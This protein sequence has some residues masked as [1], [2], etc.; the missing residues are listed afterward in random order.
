G[1]GRGKVGR[2]VQRIVAIDVVNDGASV[3][4]ETVLAPDTPSALKH[5][6]YLWLLKT[7]AGW[8][9]AG[10]LMPGFAPPGNAAGE[11][12]VPRRDAPP[13]EK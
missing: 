10:I 3:K 11:G 6:Q 4:V 8:K 12:G 7:D 2:G 1:G 9:I 5:W 13:P